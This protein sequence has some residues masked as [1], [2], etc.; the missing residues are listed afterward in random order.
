MVKFEVDGK[1]YTIDGWLKSNMDNVYRAVEKKWDGVMF[2]GGYE[3]DGKSVLAGQIAFYLDHA[4]NLDR[5]VF[6]PQQFMEAVDKAKPF[7]CIVYDEAQDAFESTRKDSMTKAIKS[8]MTRIR[9]KQLFIIIVAP[10]F[11][12]INKYIFIHRSRCFLRVYSDGLERGFFSFYNRK[13]KHQLMILGKR[14][15]SLA[16]VKPNFKARFTKWFPLDEEAYEL[17]KDKATEQ[18]NIIG[19]PVNQDLPQNMG[20][21]KMHTRKKIVFFANMLWHAKWVEAKGRKRVRYVDMVCD[22]LGISR[23]T[24]NN[25]L[26]EHGLSSLYTKNAVKG[27]RRKAQDE[28]LV[29]GKESATSSYHSDDT[30]DLPKFLKDEKIRMGDREREV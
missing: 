5:C 6:T 27:T 2:I 3:G 22:F 29:L 9:K 11:W 30:R 12:R 19:R 24:Y 4:Y 7:E 20:D 23:K 21:L 18:V 16:V 14:T 15:E 25:Y 17:K 26:K 8:K 10:D 1:K 28:G 13:R